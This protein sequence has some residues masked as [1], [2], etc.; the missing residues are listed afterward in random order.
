MY[1]TKHYNYLS[2]RYVATIKSASQNINC[3][4]GTWE[5]HTSV[6]RV[7]K[8]TGVFDVAVAFNCNRGNFPNASVSVNLTFSDWSAANYVL[9]PG[10][11]Y[12][13]NRFDWRRI[14]YSPKL[15]DPRDIG[16]GKQQIISDIPKLNFQDG[17]SK[18]QE[19]SGSMSTPGVGFYSDKL[20]SVCWILTEQGTELGDYG[21][22]IEETN[23]RQQATISITAP[24]VR[25]VYKYHLTDMRYPSDDKTINFKQ[26]DAVTIKFRIYEFKSGNLQGLFNQFAT[27]RKDLSLPDTLSTIL[28]FSSAF[29]VQE[30]KFNELNF[31]S[32]YGYYAVGARENFLQDWQ[33]GWTG[34]MISTYPLL[35][36]G[37]VPTKNNVI[38]NFDWLFP[39]GISPSGFFWDS[40]EGGNRW[41]GGDIRK[42]HT[43]DWHLVR[44]SGDGLY[45]VIRQLMIMQKLGYPVKDSWRKGTTIVV[46]AFVNLWKKNGQFG[47]FINSKSGEIIV[48]GSA[49]GGIVPGALCLSYK[50][51]GEESYL[52]IAIKAGDYYNENFVKKGI[53][54]G[55]PGDAMQNPDSESCYALLESYMLLYETTKDNRWLGIA[56]NVAMQFATWVMSYNYMFP[57]NSLFGRLDLKS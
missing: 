6:E 34:G 18:I 2:N 55:G 41:Y 7:E 17:P 27:I 15:L 9:F 25:E 47:N 49:S 13:G 33:I 22:S 48:G 14:A 31:V 4:E 45:Y 30:K 28:P 51:F 50:Y 11:V 54:C 53:T 12:K 36:A 5:I 1:D 44:K 20:H 42:P 39:A 35:V 19:R 56:E 40:G 16:P 29:K 3:P 32:E 52:D 24:V 38:K 26:G 43:A 8:R 57:L 10:A 23:D 21:I 46:D 37:S